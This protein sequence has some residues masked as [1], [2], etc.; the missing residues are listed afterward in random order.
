LCETLPKP[1][2]FGA[3]TGVPVPEAADIA[4]L[5]RQLLNAC[6]QDEYRL[7][8]GRQKRLFQLFLEMV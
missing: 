7:I 1:D 8:A 6:E 3:I 5:N 2:T 4:D